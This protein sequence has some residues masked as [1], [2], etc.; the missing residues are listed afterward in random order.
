MRYL[1]VGRIKLREVVVLL[2]ENIRSESPNGIAQHPEPANFRIFVMASLN[3]RQ[4][5]SAKFGSFVFLA[6]ALTKTAELAVCVRFPLFR[7]PMGPI[8]ILSALATTYYGE[9]MGVRG[10]SS[11]TPHVDE[12]RIFA[13]RT[14]APEKLKL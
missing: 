7:P 1:H 5:G 6:A 11:T 2:I 13:W 4:M 3:C 12:R 14:R 9:C 8:A 10:D